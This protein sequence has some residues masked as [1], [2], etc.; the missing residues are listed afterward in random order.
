[1]P[2]KE[3][4]LPFLDRIDGPAKEAGTVNTVIRK[5]NSYIGYS[6]DIRAIAELLSRRV[7]IAGKRVIVLGTG[8]TARAMAYAAV[9][10]GASVTIAGRSRR[11][12]AR[13]ARDLGPCAG[14]I[15]GGPSM[16]C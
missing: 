1:M 14:E 4:I 2:W 9:S 16:Q 13:L 6:T 3:P 5:K 8:G 15:A 10:A 11:K 12:A 7:R